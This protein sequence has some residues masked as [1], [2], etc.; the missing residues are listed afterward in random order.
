MGISGHCW[1]FIFAVSAPRKPAGRGRHGLWSRRD[2]LKIARRGNLATKQAMA[3]SISSR[4]ATTK[5]RLRAVTV[6]GSQDTSLKSATPNLAEQAKAAVISRCSR[7]ESPA[8]GRPTSRELRP[9][10]IATSRK[11]GQESKA[12]RSIRRRPR[13]HESAGRAVTV[14]ESSRHSSNRD[15][16]KSGCTAMW[17]HLRRRHGS[18]EAV[19]EGFTIYE[20]SQTSLKI[21]RPEF[22]YDKLAAVYLSLHAQKPLDEASR[23]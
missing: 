15:V 23:L 20:E 1:R 16:A 2:S 6:Y 17:R 18:H 7:H 11:S 13:N 12:A 14:Y 10:Q 8:D 4:P 19:D 22:A 5:A 9:R 21:K 3:A